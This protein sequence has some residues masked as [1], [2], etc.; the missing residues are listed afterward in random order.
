M[1]AR[2]EN[3]GEQEKAELTSYA[4]WEEP[5]Y[6]RRFKARIAAIELEQRQIIK[7]KLIEHKRK[8]QL[9][10]QNF[11][12]MTD[13]I[14]E[15]GLW[16]TELEGDQSLNAIPTKTDKIKALSAQLKFIKMFYTNL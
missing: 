6:R 12:F 7:E 14:L 4:W 16:Q 5:R 3:K 8:Y 9:K 2:L 13:D 1:L 15:W 10:L 11:F